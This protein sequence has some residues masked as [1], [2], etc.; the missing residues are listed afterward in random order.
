MS[1]AKTKTNGST[2]K[3]AEAVFTAGQENMEFAF[4][5]TIEAVMKSNAIFVQGVQDINTVIFGLAQA[6]LEDS[7]A[8]TKTIMGCKTPKDLIEVQADLAKTSYAKAM[9]DSRKISDMSVKVAEEFSK[10]IAKQV[11]ATVEKFTKPIAA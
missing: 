6:A 8:A 11:N 9:E 10:P 7:V 4:K 5:E 3:T 2:N 1:T